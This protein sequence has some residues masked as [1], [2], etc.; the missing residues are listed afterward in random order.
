MYR[1]MNETIKRELEFLSFLYV[2]YKFF[3][4]FLSVL[5]KNL[6]LCGIMF[7]I[8]VKIQVSYVRLFRT[9]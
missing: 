5:L 8:K 6:Y 9:Q 3:F 1:K 7:D 2:F 4:T